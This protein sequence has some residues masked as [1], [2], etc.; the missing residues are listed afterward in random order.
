MRRNPG[1]SSTLLLSRMYSLQ[2]VLLAGAYYRC[3][4]P[5]ALVLMMRK[6]QFCNQN[7][8]TFLAQNGGNGWATTFNISQKDVVINLRGIRQITFNANKD[9]ITLQGGA[10][11]SEVVAAAYGNNTRVITGNCDCV[12]TLGAVLGGGYG[13]LMGLYGLGVDNLLSVNLTTAYGTAI[14]VSPQDTDLWWALRGAGPNFGIVTSATM[15]AYPI[16]MANNTA[17]LG[18]LL[19]TPDKIEALVQ[20]I[21]DLDLKPEMSIFMYYA[22]F[23]PPAYQPAVIA[24]PFYLGS[25]QDGRAAFASIFAVGP[26]ADQTSIVPYSEWNAGSASFCVKG[27]RK[28]SYGAGFSHMVPATWRAIWNQYVA[29]LAANPGTGNSVVLLEAYSL[30]KTRSLPDSTSSFAL[31]G[32]NFNAVALAWY[33]DP[34]LDAAAEAFGSAV[35]DL[36]RSTDDLQSNLTY[37]IFFYPSHRSRY[38]SPHRKVLHCGLFRRYINF[39]YGDESLA[40]V[41]GSSVT[42]L[43]QIKKQYDHFGQFDQWFPIS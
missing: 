35:R 25:E 30:Y 16:A 39:A 14:Q 7:H 3:W 20:A 43:Q 36:W 37:V 32:V 18:P 40:T 28:P 10:L 4:R 21:N 22:T 12:G 6:V 41:Y 42:R 26:L 23:G 17:W 29:F 19:F 15:K 24:I 9:Q 13:R 34:S 31:R 33:S 2:Y 5:V 1:L 27:D 38:P 8:L 11:I